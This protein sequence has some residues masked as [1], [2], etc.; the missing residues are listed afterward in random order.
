M[1][2]RYEFGEKLDLHIFRKQ[3]NAYISN[4]REL[5]Y[6]LVF[7]HYRIEVEIVSPDDSTAHLAT[8]HFAEIKKDADG[9]IISANAIFPHSNSLFQDIKSITDMFPMDHYKTTIESH[10]VA[11]TVDT[12]CH[13]AKFVH[14]INNLKAFL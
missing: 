2:F 13:L 6:H 7:P 1:L 3:A 12:I 4:F 8:I 11:K 9:E 10:S 14:R 5:S